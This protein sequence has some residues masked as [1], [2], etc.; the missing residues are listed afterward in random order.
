VYICQTLYERG[1]L[2]EGLSAI[3][4]GVGKEPLVSYFASCGVNVLA[5][6]LDLSKA[7]ELGWVS[8]DQHSD[9]L[10]GLNER[11]L[12]DSEKFSALASFRTVDMNHIPQDIGTFDFC[13]SSCA[14]EHLGSIR[15]GLDFVM[16]SARLLKPG[17]IAVHTTEYN[18]TSNSKTLDNNP[19]FVIFRRCDIELLVDELKAEGFEVEPIDFSSG[20]DE[21][22]RYVDLPPYLDEPHLRLQLANEYVS[23]SLGLI[24]RAPKLERQ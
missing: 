11:A 21:L 16:N 17:G 4:F 23:T 14:F 5:T 13:W 3:G 12:C 19:S 1:Y 20:E 24:I 15:K 2:R 18:V 6:D 8:S 7:Q 10:S 22:E 9:N